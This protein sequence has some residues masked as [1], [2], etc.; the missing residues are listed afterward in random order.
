MSDPVVGD[1]K[2]TPAEDEMAAIVAAVAAVWPKTVPPTA[3]RRDV[4]RWRFSGRWWSK[5]V[6]ARRDRPR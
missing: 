6:P 2:P 1:V 4:P 5:P 3:D